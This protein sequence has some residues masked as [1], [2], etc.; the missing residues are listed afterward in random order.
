VLSD[1]QRYWQSIVPVDFFEDGSPDSENK[2]MN[3]VLGTHVRFSDKT[4]GG[5]SYSFTRAE[6]NYDSAG[7]TTNVQQI[8][9]NRSID[10]DIHGVQV[11]L[12][13][14]LRDGL[15]VQTGYR[16][17]LFDDSSPRASGTGSVVRSTNPSTTQHTF[18]L[19]ITLTSDL[20]A[21]SE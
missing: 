10:A 18:T 11:E 21:S 6:L 5:L 4:D 8:S 7:E 2:Q 15:R 17:Q 1:L 20:V 13:H 12:G 14:W 9:D 3:F 19:G 16:L